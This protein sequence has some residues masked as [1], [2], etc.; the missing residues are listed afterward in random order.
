MR[1]DSGDQQVRIIWSPRVDLVI[2]DDL[3]LRLLQ[4]TILPN[5]LGLAALPLRMTSVD[6]SNR[7]RSFPSTRVLPRKMRALVCFI[8]C[9]T[10]AA[11]ASSSRRKP[12]NASCCRR[13]VE[14][15]TLSA[16]SLENRF[17]C[18]TTRPVELSNLP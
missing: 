1:L 11:I 4:F 18:P 12:S 3:V 9:L 14:R 8:T 6:G 5:S 13:F 10:R 2:G 7:L 15:F 16:I 17:A